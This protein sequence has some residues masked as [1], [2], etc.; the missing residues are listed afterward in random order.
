M[1]NTTLLIVS[2][3]LAAAG[4]ASLG[5]DRAVHSRERSMDRW[6]AVTAEVLSVAIDRRTGPGGRPGFAPVVDYRFEAGGTQYRGER[7]GLERDWSES[8]DEVRRWV[9]PLLEGVPSQ[10]GQAGGLFGAVFAALPVGKTVTVYYDPADPARS[11]VSRWD[12]A[13][14]SLFKWL[15]LA[16]LLLGMAGIIAGAVRLLSAMAAR[17][18]ATWVGD[19]TRGEQPAR[20]QGRSALAAQLALDMAFDA[21]VR[22]ARGGPDPRTLLQERFPSLSPG[23]IDETLGKAK[24]LESICY[25]TAARVR[26]E[27]VTADAA[28]AEMAA[29][30]PGFSDQTYRAALAWGLQQCR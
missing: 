15:G 25:G 29:S 14:T 21:M 16:A 12:P 11:T 28:V 19:P 2:G 8:Q 6:V 9:E 13:A 1:S 26:S 17:P 7:L 30:Y 23:Q 5:A 18:R 27:M 22:F 24:V 4:L 10:P 3:A 20:P